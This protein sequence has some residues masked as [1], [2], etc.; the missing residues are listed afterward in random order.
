[1]NSEAQLADA[2][3]EADRA[4]TRRAFSNP[5]LALARL[6]LFLVGTVAFLLAYLFSRL[7]KRGAPARFACA[8][9]WS[10]RWFRFVRRVFGFAVH[11]RGTPPPPGAFIAPNHIGYCDLVAMGSV[12]PCFFLARADTLEWP[13]FGTLVRATEQPIV[14]RSRRKD[15][16]ES[17]GSTRL[18]LEAGLQ[19]CAFLEGTSTG[20]DRLLPFYSS[21][22][23]PALDAGAPVVPAAIRWSAA[24][25]RIRVAE[26]VAYWKDHVF[27]VHFIR[28]LGLTGVRCEIAFGEPIPTEGRDRKELAEEVRR[29]VARL[30]DFDP[31]KNFE[32]D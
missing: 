10:R 8:T 13:F 4:R 31:E 32:R 19:V 9:R 29:G 7:F 2:P 3:H 23:Q 25:P 5:A 1:M 16:G 14:T 21:F 6:I 30:G 11:V 18:R 12:T 22:L 26:D 27:V 28:L 15:L 24:S 17:A 20:G